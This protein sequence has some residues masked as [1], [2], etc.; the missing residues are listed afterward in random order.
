MIIAIYSDEGPI[1]PCGQS[2]FVTSG[3]VHVHLFDDDSDFRQ[4]VIDKGGGSIEKAIGRVGC[5][6]TVEVYE[7][8]RIRNKACLFDDHRAKARRVYLA[9]EN[10]E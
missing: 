2:C 3:H 10:I 1:G 9:R 6:Q 7:V 4:Y 8:D 5:K